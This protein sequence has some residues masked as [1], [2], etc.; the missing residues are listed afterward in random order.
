MA[1]QSNLAVVA[2]GGNSLIS[3]TAHE[4]IGDQ[5]QA[6]AMTAHYIADMIETGWNI[7]LT[8]GNGPQ[9]GFILRR[10]E[11]SIGEVPPV[12]MDYAGADLQGAIGYMFDRALRNEFNRRGIRREP[13]AVVTQTLVDRNDPAF[14]DP[15]K[16]IGSQMDEATAHRNAALQGW[17]IKSDAGRGWR[18]VV[19]SPRPKAIIELEVIRML[20]RAGYVVIAC[21][22]GG[23]PVIKDQDGNLHGT[24]AVIDKDLASSLLARDINAELLLVSTSVAQV[25]VDFGKPTQRWLDRLSLA[26]A[27]R[28]YAEDQFDRGSMGPKILAVIEFIDGGGGRGLIT[29]PENIGRALA[30]TTGTLVTNEEAGMEPMNSGSS[31]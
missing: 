9:V 5:Y 15:S 11:L 8:H 19:A 14:A 10:S 23:I 1:W 28:L 2:I 13:I 31:A 12:P 25:A 3:D 22:G 4:S 16:P 29:S 26:E 24:E 6:A 30:G 27:K 17:T 20:A 7:V 18:R 21:G